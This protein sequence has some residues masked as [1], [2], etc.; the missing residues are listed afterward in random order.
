MTSRSVV[1]EKICLL[2]FS[3]FF[4]F[5]FSFLKIGQIVCIGIQRNDALWHQNCLKR[6]KK[7]KFRPKIEIKHTITR[8]FFCLHS[9]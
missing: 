1:A 7:K 2:T 6:Q 5:L 9:F 8:P 3:F 4:V